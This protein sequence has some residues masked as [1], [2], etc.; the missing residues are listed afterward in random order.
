MTKEQDLER[1][2]ANSKPSEKE[3][4]FS[5]GYMLRMKCLTMS[6]REIV[7][8]IEN[9]SWLPNYKGWGINFLH[10]LAE[11]D[12]EQDSK[13]KNTSQTSQKSEV[14]YFLFNE[15]VKHGK[16]VWNE[17]K[18]NYYFTETSKEDA[19]VRKPY[20][21]ELPLD[22]DDNESFDHA[23]S[24]LKG[25]G[26]KWEAFRKGERV[27]GDVSIWFNSVVTR[28]TKELAHAIFKPDCIPVNIQVEG[29][30]H[31]KIGSDAIKIKVEGE[32]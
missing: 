22:L 31:F 14:K 6:L 19:N 11:Q 27:G 23:L 26:L 8:R 7:S 15:K 1:I 32:K 10:Y 20:S 16:L 12:A 17:T 18:Q 30:K 24:I 25:S 3:L 9:S 29:V 28:S 21:T 5:V 2:L 4:K 13:I